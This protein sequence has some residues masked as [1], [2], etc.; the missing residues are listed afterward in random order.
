M[1]IKKIQIQTIDNCNAKC[2]WCPNEKIYHTGELMDDQIFLKI[3]QE[4]LPLAVDDIEIDLY[5]ENEPLLDDLL[6]QRA[7][8]IKKVFPKSIIEVSTNCLLTPKYK[9]D[10]IKH[11][12]S[13]IMPIGGWDA[14][15][16]NIIHRT[17]ITQDY[18]IEIEDA[19]QEIHNTIPNKSHIRTW[20]NQVSQEDLYHPKKWY[21]MAYS[22]AGFLSNN[23]IL[24]N[25]I[26]GCVKDIPDGCLNFLYDGSAILCCMDYL[27]KTI[28]GNIKHQSITDILNSKLY[29]TYM[30]KIGGEIESEK[31]FICK[32][33]ERSK[34]V[35]C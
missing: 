5:L 29:K 18:Y 33:C 31:D 8:F 30:Q 14:E 9:E 10:I 28:L 17:N 32:L 15:S 2:V 3:I 6:F 1:K 4:A 22:R 35:S 11:L 27:R 7:Q 24:F 21:N 23:K 34:G 12:D 20:V 19:V 16:Y 25:K 26:N 13:V